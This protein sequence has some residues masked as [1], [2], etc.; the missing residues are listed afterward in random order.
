MP[1]PSDLASFCRQQHPRL[2]GMLGLYCGDRA[3][4][5][6]FAQEALTRACRDW[7]RIRSKDDPA[8]WVHRVALNLANSYFRRKLVERKATARMESGRA[9]AS[10]PDAAAAVS[11]RQAIAT[12]SKRQKTVLILRY[13]LDMS[14]P[15]V[16]E[17]MEIPLSTAKSLASRGMARLRTDPGVAE[18][19]EA[20]DAT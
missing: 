20:S 11:L 13:Y 9:S 19:K 17:F 18:L 1:A 4:A 6:E 14:F 8:A 5:E 15:E 7:M 12:L 10:E 2:V 3:I 16:A